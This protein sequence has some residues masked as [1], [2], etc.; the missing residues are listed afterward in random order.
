VNRFLNTNTETLNGLVKGQ[1]V[2][3]IFGYKPIETVSVGTLVYTHKGNFKRVIKT[4]NQSYNGKIYKIKING[5]YLPIILSEEQ[6]LYV[7][8]GESGFRN[9]DL[10]DWISAKDVRVGDKVVFACG[11]GKDDYTERKKAEFIG[12]FMIY[13]YMDN[14]NRI[15]FNTENRNNVIESLTNCGKRLD[16]K[17][18]EFVFDGVTY[19]FTTDT[20]FSDLFSSFGSRGSRYIPEGI[21]NSSIPFLKEFIK[22]FILS[23]KEKNTDMFF[24]ATSALKMLLGYQ[25]IL[26]RLNSFSN[27][28]KCVGKNKDF[29]YLAMTLTSTELQRI[30]KKDNS[31]WFR[32]FH[33]AFL[34]I[35]SIELLNYSGTIYH[36]LVE[37]DNSFCS[38]L[39]TLN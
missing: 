12:N 6:P 15:T 5:V 33:N 35:E 18:E 30:G 34:K 28:Y 3:T 19:M 31:L 16:I 14:E 25:R 17:L 22:P 27:I 2:I 8:R 4:E 37:E 20:T 29:E 36:L 1:N 21:I 24:R 13:G 7:F 9:K 39:F 11:E 10:F 26:L 23:N 38:T 32:N